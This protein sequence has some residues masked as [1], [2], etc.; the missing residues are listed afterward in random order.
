[1]SP[2]YQTLPPLRPSVATRQTTRLDVRL[3]RFGSGYVHRRASDLTGPRRFWQVV[4]RDLAAAEITR[5]D[6]FLAAHRGLTPFY[7]T[8]PGLPGA[9]LY[10]CSSWQITPRTGSLS[11]LTARFDLE[12]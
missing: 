3:T 11:D 2:A 8:P 4:W 10:I 1:M 12:A 7:W 6:G 9:G 5:L